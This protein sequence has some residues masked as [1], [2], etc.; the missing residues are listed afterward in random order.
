MQAGFSLGRM[1][2]QVLQAN[3]RY[4]ALAT[5]VANSVAGAT[6]TA[7]SGGGDR[8]VAAAGRIVQQ[9]QLAPP[10][11]PQRGHSAI[12]LEGAAGSKPTALFLLEN[13]MPHEVSASVEI[14]PRSTKSGRKLKSTLQIDKQKIV[15]APGQQVVA[16]IS[17]P[18]T[19]KLV[20]GEQYTGEIRVQ[21]IPG[22]S[23]PLVLRR[24]TGPQRVRSR[25]RLTAVVSANSGKKKKPSRPGRR[26]TV[27]TVSRA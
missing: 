10:V 25:Q 26:A 27:K 21:G 14:T 18:I 7:F 19:T 3:L 1:M 8:V 6:F 15:L 20:T 24:I 4:V 5:R 16:R 11:Q 9:K 17:A 2:D 12:V 22:A 23:V 13:H